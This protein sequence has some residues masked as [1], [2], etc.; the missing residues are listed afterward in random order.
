[1]KR[2]GV[3]VAG[4]V[5]LLLA[6]GAVALVVREAG[7]FNAG[8][9]IVYPVSAVSTGLRQHPAAWLGRT[10]LVRGVVL[11]RFLDPGCSRPTCPGT[12]AYSLGPALD[13]AGAPG[14]VLLPLVPGQ[15]SP[16]IAAFRRIPALRGFLPGLQTVQLFR[17]AT[18]RVRLQE[19]H[20]GCGSGL[21]TE[22]ILM[23][24]AS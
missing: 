13:G 16:W 10:V 18:Y 8:A 7:R 3:G 12:G 22:A 11:G 23:D 9:R 24:G 2:R 6:S 14:A 19:G 1:M 15:A 17:E 21:C 5:A 4:I 20:G